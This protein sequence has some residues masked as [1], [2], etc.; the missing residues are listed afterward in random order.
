M[1][2]GGEKR[3]VHSVTSLAKSLAHVV[4]KNR[5]LLSVNIWVKINLNGLSY[6]LL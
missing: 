6:D 5:R 3:T 2:R 4:E 1:E